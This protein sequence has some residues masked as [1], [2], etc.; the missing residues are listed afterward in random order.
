MAWSEEPPTL[1]DMEKHWLQ[2]M[3]ERYHHRVYPREQLAS[4]SLSKAWFGTYPAARHFGKDSGKREG[5]PERSSRRSRRDSDV[6]S[7]PTGKKSADTNMLQFKG[8]AMSLESIVKR[9][10]NLK[11]KKPRSGLPSHKKDGKPLLLCFPFMTKGM[12]CARGDQ[13]QF[14]HLCASSEEAKTAQP[15]AFSE[16]KDAIDG[17]LKDCF[18]F[19]AEGRALVGA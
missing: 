4:G 5:D 1:H 16:L 2:R 14:A 10:R 15:A 11:E 9:M 13:C 18:E 19:T 8:D 3:I 12:E 6:Q 7:K 17:K